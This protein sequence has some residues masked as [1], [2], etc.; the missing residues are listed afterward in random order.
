[1]KPAIVV[2]FLALTTLAAEQPANLLRNPDFEAPDA[3]GWEKRTPNDPNRELK[4]VSADAHSG[5]RLARLVN[6]RATMSRW[7]QGAD[8][9]LKAPPGS[10]VRLTGWIRTELGREG[11][12]A[13]RLY[14]MGQPDK[15]LIQPQTRPVTG[16]S[17]WKRVSL[18]TTVPRETDHLMVYLE[19]QNAVGTADFD[20]VALTLVAP[21][22]PQT[23]RNDLLLITDAPPD[24]PT[25]RS[26]QTLYPERLV[27][28]SPTDKP[29]W[30]KC[31][32]AIVFSRKPETA[33]DL[34][35]VRRFA[36]RGHPVVVDLGIFAR[37]HALEV[38]EIATTNMPSLRIL[39]EHPATRGFQVDDVI[40]WCAGKKGRWTQRL[41]PGRVSQ[42]VLAESSSGGTLVVA[43]SAGKGM[44]LAG[45]LATLPEPAYNLPG[46][47]NKY[48]FAGN[49]LGQ[50]VR[51]GRHY[52]RRL[53][54]AEFVDAMRALAT[55]LPA[56]RIEDDG[57]AHGHYRLHSLNLGDP[58]KPAFLVYGVTHGSEWES[59]YGLLTLARL[60]AS[61]T[62]SPLFDTRHYCLKLIPILNPSGYELNTR[63]N[64]ARVDLNRNG[65]EWWE[66]FKGR[67][68]NNDGTWG[69][70]DYD[71][72][73][74]GPFSEP[75][76][77]TLRTVIDRLKPY[78]TL[79][80]HGNG[81]GR[82]NNRLVVLPLTA[83]ADNEER[84]DA[85]V[86]GFNASLSNR[87]VLLEAQRPAVEQYEIEAVQPDSQR[88]TLIQTACRNRYGFLCE[89]PAGYPG[90][91][92]LVM[93]TDVV[94]ET[95]LAFFNAYQQ[96]Q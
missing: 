66:S 65:G 46:S 68:S 25:V 75:E 84:A 76:T 11:Y 55:E 14:C 21:P 85:A 60:L 50:T 57:P 77:Q 38:R 2:L 24:D 29:A 1:M 9:T 5:Q 92:G 47:F 10:V 19:L 63:Q 31:R 94:V 15:I 62:N 4:I 67:D 48:L 40:P 17:D 45:D 51:H 42:R 43:E 58:Q 34:D 79:D 81:G 54:Y 18:T 28:A 52:P 59:A 13:L 49:L 7:R 23:A 73:G 30:E 16:K 6:H 96:P 78:A 39:Q 87:Y 41:L 86:R 12:A 95:C 20:D 32:A 64:A 74:T 3:A 69:P 37:W 53:S 35:A 72:K 80:F 44:I 61:Q 90:T 70:G 89:V 27:L 93:Q 33:F 88:P 56:L 83:R 91:Y 22:K 26:L 36:E 8:G 71:W 82:G